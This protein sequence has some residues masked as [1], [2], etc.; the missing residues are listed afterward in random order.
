MNKRKF[1]RLAA[2]AT[3]LV[4]AG[5]LISTMIATTGAYFTDSHSGQIAGNNGTVQIAVTGSGAT[6]AG[7]PSLVN[8]D[9]SG[10]LPGVP[11]TATVHVSN[12]TS[13][14]EDIWLVFD[15]SNF[16]WSAVNNLGQYGKFQIGGYV[17]DN[18]ANGYQSLTPGVAGTPV[19]PPKFMGGD[20]S[21]IA[22]VGANALPHAIFIGT[23][24]G[25][26]STSFPMTFTYNACM[27]NHQ[28]ESIF[29]AAEA[30]GTIAAAVAG[31]GGPGPLLF[32]VVAFQPGVDPTD[33]FNG[34]AAITPIPNLGGLTWLTHTPPL[35]YKYQY[36]Q[37]SLTKIVDQTQ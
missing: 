11:T 36:I 29:N 25:G 10:I 33:P 19:N 35:Y 14:A 8:F 15:N 26:T 24:A 12:P 27:T 28:G 1:A 6:S 37:Y 30:D 7:D 2:L 16:M 32:N 22:R 4:A 17:Y 5:A 34:S 20:C 23:L 21:S 3:T 9:F 13:G 31:A 18:L